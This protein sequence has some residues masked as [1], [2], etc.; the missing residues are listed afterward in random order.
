MVTEEQAVRLRPMTDAEFAEWLPR[1]TAE[2]AAEI[3]ASGAMPT[4]AARAKAEQDNARFFHAGPSTPGQHVF[5][6]LAGG[7]PVGRLWLGVPGPNPDPLMAWVFDIEIDPA[8][9]GRG[10]GREAM[11]LAEEE[12]RARGM[13]SL[14]LNVHGPN[15]VA[16]SLYDALGYDVMAL[17]LKK[18][19]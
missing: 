5:M 17:Q 14:G 1:L 2:Y 11:L 10:Y 13:K 18:P 19:L 15:T 3:E 7:T 4:A 12:A 16:R 6:V 8:Y 9:R